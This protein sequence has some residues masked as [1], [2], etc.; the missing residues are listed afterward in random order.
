MPINVLLQLICF[1]VKYL[2]IPT[3]GSLRLHEI[4]SLT[5]KADLLHYVS[6]HGQIHLSCFKDNIHCFVR[7]MLKTKKNNLAM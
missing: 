3:T 4:L 2:N 5:E 1:A 6:P 7:F